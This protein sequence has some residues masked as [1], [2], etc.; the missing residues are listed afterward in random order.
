MKSVRISLLEIGAILMLMLSLF[1]L[2]H[3]GA[4]DGVAVPRHYSGG[5]ADAWGNRT[6]F[7]W[8]GVIALVVYG[9]LFF[10]QK[11]PQLINLSNRSSHDR[12]SMTDKDRLRAV[13]IA[14]TLKFW[15]LA[16]IA[17]LSLCTYLAATGVP[18]PPT[19]CTYLLLVLMFG[20]LLIISVQSRRE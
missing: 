13:A 2:L 6:M 8:I 19:W 11:H 16:V 20:H 7:L 18:N 4:L 3:Y 5:V 1:P 15:A 10:C 12:A 14:R 17:C 9:L